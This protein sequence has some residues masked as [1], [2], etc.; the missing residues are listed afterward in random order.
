MPKRLLRTAVPL[1]ALRGRLACP[2]SSKAPVPDDRARAPDIP[3]YRSLVW[4][5]LVGAAAKRLDR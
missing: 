3:V 5:A 2:R 4:P 1:N